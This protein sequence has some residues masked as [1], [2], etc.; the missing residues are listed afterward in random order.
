MVRVPLINKDQGCVVPDGKV[1]GT[2]GIAVAELGSQN[3]FQDS[4]H[5]LIQVLEQVLDLGVPKWGEV[6]SGEQGATIER[7]CGTWG[8]LAPQHIK[9]LSPKQGLVMWPESQLF[10]R[11]K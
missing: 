4:F 9:N 3:L 6:G 1:Q 10:W 11:L 8:L 7:V 5:Q 2:G